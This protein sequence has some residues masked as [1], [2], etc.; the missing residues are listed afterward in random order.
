MMKI[1]LFDS[2]IGSGGAE[3]VLTTMANELVK[4]FDVSV[5]TFQSAP[6]DVFYKI[7]SGVNIRCLDLLK[8]SN[9]LVEATRE[10]LR[11]IKVLRQEIK[12]LDPDVIVSFLPEN[13]ILITLSCLGYK[14]PII[15]TEHTDPFGTKLGKAWNALR[16][17][18][19]R[20][21][22]V[23]VVLTR[24][25]KEYFESRFS[26]PVV[27]IP[28]PVSLPVEKEDEEILEIPAP[29]IIT[30]GRLVKNKRIED[31]ISAFSQIKNEYDDWSL[32]IVGDGPLKEDLQ[33]FARE[34]GV[35]ERVF[36]TGL[37]R[38]PGH[39]LKNAEMFVSA[40]STEVFPMA[41]CE[42]MICKLP[43][44]VREYNESVRDIIDDKINGIL[45]DDYS[46]G[47]LIAAIKELMSD[48]KRRD[49]LGKK[50]N[51]AMQKFTP[52]VVMSS[53]MDLFEQLTSKAE[54]STKQK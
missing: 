19:Y 13:N 36:F 47:K 24:S 41:I 33:E 39:L 46:Q 48:Q 18:V 27:V 51:I 23:I 44:V 45:V 2:M 54:T 35:D 20:Q 7:N 10:N 26:I 14:K 11:R 31:I 52:D 17:L 50:A 37:V 8:K 38:S 25:A 42:A 34:L 40:S 16:R 15:L 9:S 49:I 1:T 43:V 21:A 3:R 32:V 6:E 30:I 4:K 28:N 29:Y 5:V 12:A 22:D 53:W